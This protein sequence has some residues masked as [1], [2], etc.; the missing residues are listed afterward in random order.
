ME[1]L[2]CYNGVPSKRK[3]PPRYYEATNMTACLTICEGWKKKSKNKGKD[4]IGATIVKMG[5]SQ[6]CNCASNDEWK[7]ATGVTGKTCLLKGGKQLVSA[8]NLQ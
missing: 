3:F 5:R 6:R 2:N 4:T 1:V 7:Q 8:G